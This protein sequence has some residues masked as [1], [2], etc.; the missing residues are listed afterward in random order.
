M[1]QMI[2]YMLAQ[3]NANTAKNNVNSN[4]RSICL[5]TFRKRYWGIELILS[6]I[7]YPSWQSNIATIQNITIQIK[8]KIRGTQL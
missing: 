5:A 3:M 8:L 7:F 6:R 1:Q 2:E 4:K